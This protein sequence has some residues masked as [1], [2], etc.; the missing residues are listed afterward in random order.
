[1]ECKNCGS[2]DIKTGVCWGISG[3]GNAVGLKYTKGLFGRTAEVCSDVCLDCG[4]INRIYV[5][6][7]DLKDKKWRER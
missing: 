6:E 1:M 4:E 7:K 3:E 2:Q 5:K